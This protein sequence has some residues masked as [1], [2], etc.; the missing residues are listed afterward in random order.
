MR[1]GRRKGSWDGSIEDFHP[2]KCQL[3]CPEVWQ[4]AEKLLE[5]TKI[6]KI[7]VSPYLRTRQTASVVAEVAKQKG[8]HLPIRVD[9]RLGE[10]VTPYKVKP[11]AEEFD[12]STLNYY[13]GKVSLGRESTS[14]FCSRV[15]Q[16]ARQ[17]KPGTLVITH[18]N[19]AQLIIFLSHHKQ[20]EFAE[21]QWMS[22]RLPN[23]VKSSTQTYV[24]VSSRRLISPTTV[25]ES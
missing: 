6:S 13:G 19:V 12:P 23:Y 11:C 21:G 5:E 20:V 17:L 25:S 16:F 22:Y 15:E 7:I 8:L 10:F 9:V 4:Q 1:H 18:L 24:P 14:M 2:A 3:G